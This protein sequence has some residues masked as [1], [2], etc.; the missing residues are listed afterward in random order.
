MAVP[1]P[2]TKRKF[3]GNTFTANHLVD[4]KDDLRRLKTRL[5]NRGVLARVVDTAEGFVVFTRRKR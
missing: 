3:N 2:G 5:R 1:G 4:T